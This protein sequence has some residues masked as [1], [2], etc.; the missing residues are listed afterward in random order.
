MD[1]QDLLLE[2]GCEELPTHAVK[3][4]SNELHNKICTLLSAQKL[5]YGDTQAFATP[6][7]I[8][9][10]INGLDAQQAAQTIERQGPPYS[11]AYDANSKPTPT[12]LGFAQ[13]CGV[14]V[15]ALSFLETNKGKR[16]YF[17]GEKAGQ[18]T[19]DLLPELMRQ[20]ITQLPIARPMRWGAHTESFARPVHWLL[21]LY[22]REI[23]K[24]NMFGL[25]ASN[26][27]YGHRFHNPDM[28]T[29]HEPKDYARTLHE[30]GKVIAD[31]KERYEKICQKIQAAIPDRKATR[32]SSSSKAGDPKISGSSAFAED[33]GKIFTEDDGSM[34]AEGGGSA[35]LRVEMD[36]ELLN[37]VTSLVEWPVALCGRFNPEFLKVPQEALITSMKINQKYFPVLDQEGRLQ[38]AFILISNINSKDPAL[39]I[40]GNE[41]VLNARLSDAAF[42]YKNDCAHSL[43]SR[44]PQLQHI[45]FQKQLGSIGDKTQR[46]M[47]LTASIA[48]NIGADAAAQ[49][50]A[51]LCKCDLLS[52]MV[53]EFPTL[54]GIMGYYYALNDG[55][56]PVCATAIKEHYYPRFA[57]DATP[58]NLEGCAVSL[59]DKLDTLIGIFGINQIPSGDKDPFA[60]RRAANGILHILIEK[61]L[62]VDLMP[63][64]QETQKNYAIHLPNTDVVSQAYDFI[65]QRL[66]SLCLEKSF[67]AEQFEAVLAC[68]PPQPLDF[69]RRIHAVR[70][71]QKLPEAAALAAANK[72][73]SNILKK[74]ITGKLPEKIDA[75][76]FEHDAERVLAKQ[77]ESISKTVTSLYQETKYAEA[78]KKLAVLKEPVDTF[79]DKVMVMVED[80]RLRNNR[81]ALLAALHCLFTQVA[82]ISLL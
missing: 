25:H 23:I 45:V 1:K 14:P 81:I 24:I 9:V 5:N 29:I 2:I 63:L 50:A 74:Q 35:Q 6:R 44:L 64:L 75:A 19:F 16:L 56:G 10:I 34:F 78:L 57:S 38:P 27:T 43:Q 36:T 47:T 68:R 40:H 31:F 8:A 69:M 37:E 15:E 33:D 49:L 53:G 13:S 72:R 11:Q 66:K 77:L 17:K 52:E 4:L 62:A 39:V 79:F 54:Q 21:C 7:R 70:E 41:R 20:A 55:L 42:F 60:L 67:S 61:Q 58:S 59:A 22:G 65:M 48:K 80:E 51:Q 26:H 73:V 12:A 28:L 82:D 3:T 46:I 18:S 32:T 71:F 76:L 30:H